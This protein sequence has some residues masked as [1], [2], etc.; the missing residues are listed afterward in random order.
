MIGLGKAAIYI[1]VVYLVWLWAAA[2]TPAF[3]LPPPDAVFSEFL[4][5]P[6]LLADHAA[7]TATAAVSGAVLATAIGFMIGVVL[8]FGGAVARAIEPLVVA[9][10]V[11]PKE[12]LGPILLII[13]GYGIASKIAIST[14]IAVFPVV[15]AVHRGLSETP[16]SYVRLMDA[17]GASPLVRF[18][19]VQ[20]PHAIPHIFSGI[21][22]CVTLAL[23][24]A[25]VGEYLGSSEGL[26]FLMRSSLS[27]QAVARIYAAMIL[28][29]AIGGGFYFAVSAIERLFFSAYLV[30]N[31]ES[32]GRGVR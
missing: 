3:L 29:G 20:L 7:F 31:E 32:S 2:R 10:Q 16:P 4:K 17:M 14:M 27:E 28:L 23:I 25:I 12:A 8:R 21:R 1:G 26:G 24:G 30:Q 9:M 15:V 5:Y 22:V 18:A 13:F 6:Q 11:F 19:A